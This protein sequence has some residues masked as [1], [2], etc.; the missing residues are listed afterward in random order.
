MKPLV[1]TRS[2]VRSFLVRHPTLG[3]AVR[4]RYHPR[5]IRLYSVGAPKTGTM[6]VARLFGPRYRGAHE[7]TY[8]EAIDYLARRRA[9]TVSE[10]ELRQWLRRRDVE[11]WS[12]CESSH[13]LCWFSDLVQAE[14]PDAKFVVTVRDAYPWANSVIDQHLNTRPRPGTRPDTRYTRLRDLYYGAKST[15]PGDVLTGLGEY[16]LGGYVG[17]WASHYAYLLDHLEP[18]RTLFVRTHEIGSRAAEIAEFAGVPA[19]TLTLGRSH[20][21]EA[22]QKHDVLGRMDP[23]RVRD[24]ILDLCG[25]VAERLHAVA[26]VGSA[27]LLGLRDTQGASGFLA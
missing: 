22:P 25:P 14:F 2:A 4:S 10:D 11:V 16:T 9:G 5:W 3:R 15:E 13:V 20:S 12:G 17:Y 19:S 18:E 1:A 26:G 23:R 24:T 21:H 8:L 6:S 7:G 27:D